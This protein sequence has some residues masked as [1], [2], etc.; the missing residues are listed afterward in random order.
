[1]FNNELCNGRLANAWGLGGLLKAHPQNPSLIDLN[2]PKYTDL[3][4]SV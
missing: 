3:I 2:T 1:M 4:F